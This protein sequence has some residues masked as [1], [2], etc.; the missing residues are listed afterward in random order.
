MNSPVIPR[1][2][3]EAFLLNVLPK[4]TPQL[5]VLFLRLVLDKKRFSIL[6]LIETT[7]Q[8]RSEKHRGIRKAELISAIAVE[9]TMEQKLISILEKKLSGESYFASEL[10]AQPGKSHPQVKVRLVTKVDPSLLGG[11]ILKLDERVVDASYKTKLLEMR[12]RLS[13]VSV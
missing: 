6:R 4:E 12:Q 8:S 10:S 13:A 9:K 5:L 11:F 7:F 2:K 1:D 3:K